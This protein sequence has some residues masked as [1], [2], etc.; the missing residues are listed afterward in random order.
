MSA[1]SEE[2]KAMFQAISIDPRSVKVDYDKMK[3]NAVALFGQKMALAI[4][5]A[6]NLESL[7]KWDGRVFRIGDQEMTYKEF[8]DILD[9]QGSQAMIDGRSDPSKRIAIDKDTLTP[10]RFAKAFARESIIYLTMKPDA[11]KFVAPV[12]ATDSN[13]VDILPQEYVFL[14]SPYGMKD[15]ML[16][17][18]YEGLMKF[19]NA[20]DKIVQTAV[21]QKWVRDENGKVVIPTDGKKRTWAED[22]V[23]YVK[24]RGVVV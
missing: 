3:V 5:I 4:G 18:N 9:G 16:K 12:A 17:K 10:S 1:L 6:L 7:K 14:N 20:F 21:Q 11:N 8:L 2:I 19:Y 23:N 22:F 15:D 24:F 13:V